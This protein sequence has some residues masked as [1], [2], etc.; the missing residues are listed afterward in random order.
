MQYHRIR[1]SHRYPPAA[2]VSALQL[3]TSS[4]QKKSVVRKHLKQ[5]ITPYK[6]AHTN[7]IYSF[8]ITSPSCPIST[9]PSPSAI[10]FLA[11][12]PS[13]IHLFNHSP[14]NTSVGSTCSLSLTQFSMSGYMLQKS[15]AVGVTKFLAQ[16]GFPPR[17]FMRYSKAW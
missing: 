12:S 9:N 17:S 16:C 6:R 14:T 11:S 4:N 5:E 10:A 15:L 2:L 7:H 3:Q 8:K 13:K 1:K